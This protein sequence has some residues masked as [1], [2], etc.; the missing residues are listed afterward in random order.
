MNE[1]SVNSSTSL[2]CQLGC[3]S[4]KSS[5]S[6]YKKCWSE[7]SMIEQAEL[8][9]HSQ[10]TSSVV[11]TRFNRNNPDNSTVFVTGVAFMMR[12]AVFL[13]SRSSNL[14]F[15]SRTLR[16]PKTLSSLELRKNWLLDLC[17]LIGF[18]DL[19]FVFDFVDEPSVSSVFDADSL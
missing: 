8:K 1:A 19:G 6:N 7:V 3:M 5:D 18:S 10:Q 16:L 15:R 12:F 4:D 14:L 2:K 13:K 11:V 17:N 9:A